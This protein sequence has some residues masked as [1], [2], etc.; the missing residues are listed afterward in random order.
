MKEN[1]L[2]QGTNESD[3]VMLDRCENSG[4][5]VLLRVV[6]VSVASRAA[7][8][9]LQHYKPTFTQQTRSTNELSDLM[10]HLL[11]QSSCDILA[12]I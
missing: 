9:A 4:E 10:Q 11:T 2:M 1:V 12:G 6:F 7:E 5:A 8:R 3:D